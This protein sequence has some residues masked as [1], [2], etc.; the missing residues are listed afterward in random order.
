MPTTDIANSEN[1]LTLLDQ[2]RALEDEI[3]FL[4]VAEGYAK[5]RLRGP[6]A[7]EAVIEDYYRQYPEMKTYVDEQAS[8]G[9]CLYAIREMRMRRKK[10]LQAAQARRSTAPPK[11]ARDPEMAWMEPF[12]AKPMAIVFTVGRPLPP[13]LWGVPSDEL[14][15]AL[16]ALPE[17]PTEQAAKPPSTADTPAYQTGLPGRPTSWF[18]VEAEVRRR[19][20]P[21][22]ASKATAEWTLDMSAWVAHEHPNAPTPKNK[23]LGNRLAGLLRELKASTK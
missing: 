11:F 19:F 6:I 5:H 16:E 15:S 7:R 8:K 14:D 23:T 2:K 21:D 22:C 17:K 18:L 1:S 10:G 3:W 4:A 9:I 13:P 12:M 20:G